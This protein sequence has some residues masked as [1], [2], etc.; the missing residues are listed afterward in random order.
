MNKS[1]NPFDF[2]NQLGD[3]GDMRK[4]LGQDFFKN[5][6]LPNM[7]SMPFFQEERTASEFPAIDLY[8]RST[9]LIA[10]IALPG[11][12]SASDVALSVRS[13]FLR[14]RGTVPNYFSGTHEQ[15][16]MSEIFHGAFDREIELPERVLPDST[17]AMYR[18]GLLVVYLQK[19]QAREQPGDAIAIDFSGDE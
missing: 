7:Q 1:N 17:K 12:K 10:A 3:L 14:V 2:I 18:S 19:D 11:L 6:P 16:M 8:N 15:K 9:E 4:F 13:R 5:L